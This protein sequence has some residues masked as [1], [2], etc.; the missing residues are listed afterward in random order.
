MRAIVKKN[1][2]VVNKEF[3]QQQQITDTKKRN[4]IH[5]LCSVFER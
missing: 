4:S 5:K 2:L 3:L 1:I